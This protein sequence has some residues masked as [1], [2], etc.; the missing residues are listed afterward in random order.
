[1]S[2]I[3]SFDIKNGFLRQYRTTANADDIMVK[4]FNHGT[5]LLKCSS[6]F[7]QNCFR[8]I[9][10]TL[11]SISHKVCT[12]KYHMD[13]YASI[14]SSIGESLHDRTQFTDNFNNILIDETSLTAEYESFLFQTKAALDVLSMFLNA[15]YTGK[16]GYQKLNSFSDRGRGVIR[17]LRKF[18]THSGEESPYLHDLIE[19]LETE[20]PDGDRYPSGTQSWFYLLKRQR[21]KIAHY[22]REFKFAFQVCIKNNA[23]IITPPMANEN[24][25]IL[26]TI[27]IIYSNLLVFIQDFLAHIFR[28][29]LRKEFVCFCYRPNTTT[30]DAPKWFLSLQPFQIFDQIAY[31]QNVAELI[32]RSYQ[33]YSM[34]SPPMTPQECQAMHLYYF[35][36]FINISDEI[37]Q[38]YRITS[39]L[40]DRDILNRANIELGLI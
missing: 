10:E 37:R 34:V 23:V 14:E 16:R 7:G 8:N 25:T 26:Q 11:I 17:I 15:I 27:Q 39:N 38:F 19:Y 2:T 33:D 24:Q 3:N 36:F 35:S 9:A 22:G 40:L 30:A 4:V 31:Q 18:L 21:D 28:P 13:R 20:C 1:M 5:N 32:P 12:V 29:Y 6:F